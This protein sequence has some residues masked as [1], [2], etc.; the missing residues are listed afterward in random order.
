MSAINDDPE[1]FETQQTRSYRLSASVLASAA[2]RKAAK[3]SP[4]VEELPA[5]HVAQH[6][7]LH[8][9]GW[10]QN[11]MVDT[12]EVLAN[13][14]G[15]PKNSKTPGETTTCL[16]CCIHC[17]GPLQPGYEGTTVR[18]IPQNGKTSRSRRRKLSRRTAK[19][20]NQTKNAARGK[21][22]QQTTLSQLGAYA[23]TAFS[24]SQQQRESEDAAFFR[25]AARSTKHELR[26]SR[27]RLSIR[28]PCHGTTVLQGFP[29]KKVATLQ[30]PKEKQ[31]TQSAKRTEPK[32]KKKQRFEDGF[33]SVFKPPTAKMERKE[34]EPSSK[35]RRQQDMISGVKG[36][37][38]KKKNVLMDFL[39]KLND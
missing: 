39:S 9:P 12:S 33:I 4:V 16:P 35:R 2:L 5:I 17:G 22:P 19:I 3:S 38:Q 21:Q 6:F 23:C 14:K 15:E 11:R 7:L 13:S 28:C 18:L 20:R 31:P 36:K 1:T 24:E 32:S 29:R 27:N 10:I 25:Q 37:D 34:Q 8:H 26:N 30:K